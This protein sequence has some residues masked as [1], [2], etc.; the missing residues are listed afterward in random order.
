VRILADSAF[1]ID[2]LNGE[3]AALARWREVFEEGDEPI[4]NEIVVCEVSTGL[5]PWEV[6]DFAAFLEPVEFIQPG[7][8]TALLAGRWRAEAR[9]AGR[10]L[11]LADALIAAAAFSDNAAVLT[12][13]ARDFALTPVQLVTY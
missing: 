7:L 9:A 12:R 1:I 4:I 5:K 11:G 10:T 2:Y 13:N 8:D 3:P 6:R